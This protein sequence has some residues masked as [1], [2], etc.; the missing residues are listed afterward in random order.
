MNCL[1]SN[2]SKA[3]RQ[4]ESVITVDPSIVPSI[5]TGKLQHTEDLWEKGFSG[6]LT[7]EVRLPQKG[8][9]MYFLLSWQKLG[10]FFTRIQAFLV[11]IVK[12]GYTKQT[13]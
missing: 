10:I 12:N 11:K 1:K 4:E 6:G 3:E 13:L 7:C 8:Q 9:I 5:V 2:V